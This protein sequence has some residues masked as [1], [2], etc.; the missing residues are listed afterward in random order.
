MHY[1]DINFRR[2]RLR[3]LCKSQPISI[4][5][6][7]IMAL[8]FSGLFWNRFEMAHYL[9]VSF[10]ILV[11]MARWI[12]MRTYHPIDQLNPAKLSRFEKIYSFFFACSGMAWGLIPILFEPIAIVQEQKLFYVFALGMMVAAVSRSYASRLCSFGYIAGILTPM[13][14]FESTKMNSSVGIVFMFAIVIF[15][16]F[17]ILAAK[18][19]SET[20]DNRI[21]MFE[22]LKDK[23]SIEE[24]LK[25]QKIINA[26]S[27]KMAALGELSGEMAHEINNPLTIIQ[28]HARKLQ[29][30][31][32]DAPE[33]HLHRIQKILDTT[34]RI[35]KI[36]H[37]LKSYS[38]GEEN[39]QIRAMKLDQ[40]FGEIEDLISEK[41]RINKIDIDFSYPSTQA[42]NI[43]K[44]ALSQVII[45]LLNNAINVLKDQEKR[46]ISVKYRRL[47]N[48]EVF[49]V[50]D[51]GPGVPEPMKDK[52]FSPYYTTKNSK[53]GLGL[54]LSISKKLIDSMGGK[55][56]IKDQLPTTFVI[57]LPKVEVP[58]AS[59]SEN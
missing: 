42:V 11:S 33:F 45:N 18:N 57:S 13:T 8:L 4:Y 23:F 34:E 25:Q 41:S 1:S 49:E 26:H 27:V 15:F 12:V 19:A 20:Y 39:E 5:F 31:L 3:E 35:S 7:P 53:D 54:G 32:H 38:E 16:L 48:E 46:E 59:S 24:E 43:K 30:S 44:V 2:T 50:M 47:P 56:F 9:W 21:K 37:G 36:V 6:N 22:S 29:K 51:S 17:M 52:I 14:L 10:N 28:G 55:L 58:L 40:F